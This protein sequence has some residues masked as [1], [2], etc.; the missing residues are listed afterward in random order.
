M[1]LLL[2]LAAALPLAAQTRMITAERFY[3]SFDHRHPVLAKIRPGEKIQTRLLDAGGYDEAKV[4]KGERGNPLTGPFFV[5]GAE[6]GDA[7]V[8]ALEKIR[9]TRDWGFTSD[10]LGLFSLTPESVEGLYARGTSVGE[11]LPERS[12]ILRW[13]IDIQKGV[14]KLH[15]PRS[16]VHSLEF[17]VRSMLG[18]IGVAA[19]GVFG[20]TSGISGPYG[21]NMDYNE[22]IEGATVMLPVY[23]PGA[24]LFLGD[25]HAVQ[26]DG[27]PLGTGIETTMEV[28]FSVTLRKKAHLS[29]PRLENA[30]WIASVGSQPEFASSLD[31]S[32]RL[33]TSD[34]V[35]WL[36]KDYRM[37][38]W[39]AH[40][41]VG[42]V[43]R[44]DV[45]TVAGSMA[46][47]IPKR[48]LPRR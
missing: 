38:P 30:E 21:G 47:R 34:M 28:I 18:C 5:E 20:P 37:E 42:S 1:K 8:V 2:A 17:P 15:A 39:A 48:H 6:A 24:L 43:G 32:L 10:R 36:V 35:N 26:A 31:R 3:N 14:A 9:I 16:Q 45:V 27:E 4:R 29:N 40:L 46:L 22:V 19:E 33:A 7:I 44:Y 13:D 23:H 41:L 25:G 11:V 12:S